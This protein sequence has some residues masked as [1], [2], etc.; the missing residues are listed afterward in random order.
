MSNATSAPIKRHWTSF[1]GMLEGGVGNF[2]RKHRRSA[3]ELSSL[4]WSKYSKTPVP[5]QSGF[6]TAGVQ[7][8]VAVQAIQ[9]LQALQTLQTLQALAES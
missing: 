4:S 3:H 9:A 1:I 7:S 2:F 6:Q 5:V 8:L